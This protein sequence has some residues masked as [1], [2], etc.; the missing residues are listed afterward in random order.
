MLEYFLLIID[1][2]HGNDNLEFIPWREWKYQQKEENVNQHFENNDLNNRGSQSI[3]EN[4]SVQKCKTT[5][6]GKLFLENSQSI[7][8]NKIKK[9]VYYM[10]QYS[11]QNNDMLRNID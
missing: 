3:D 11:I 7:P 5:T 1:F 2:G 8:L 4:F 9:F 6:N 10:K